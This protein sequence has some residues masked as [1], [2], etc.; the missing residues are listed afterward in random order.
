[1]GL[2]SSTRDGD[3]IVIEDF[4]TDTIEYLPSHI[5]R[6][7]E[8]K[9]VTACTDRWIKKLWEYLDEHD[10]NLFIETL[11]EAGCAKIEEMLNLSVLP[12]DTLEDRKRRIRGVFVSSLPYTE[13]KV[14]A[15]L[16][17]MCQST[18]IS[19]AV[20]YAN[21]SVTVTIKTDAYSYRDQLYDKARRMIPANMKL[22]FVIIYN[23]W[24]KAE[25]YTWDGISKWTWDDALTSNAFGG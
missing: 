9:V 12:T 14:L 23:A 8:F 15:T 1:M 25:K 3:V 22:L 4:R 7:E 10:N 19:M 5:R 20:D 16:M 24:S 17:S 18:N 13:K 11:D 6:I 21:Y 2:C